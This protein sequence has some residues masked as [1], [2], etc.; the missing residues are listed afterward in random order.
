MKMG[1]QPH[2]DADL[3]HDNLP[4]SNMRIGSKADRPSQEGDC[5][6]SHLED[7]G[8]RTP[9]ASLLALRGLGM[10]PSPLWFDSIPINGSR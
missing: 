6:V 2:D 10:G 4:V 1:V 7:R 8:L 9:M 5:D 3:Q